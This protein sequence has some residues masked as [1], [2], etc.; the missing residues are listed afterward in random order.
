MSD[1]VDK[2]GYRIYQKCDFCGRKGA[3]YAVTPDGKAYPIVDRV[4]PDKRLCYACHSRRM[5]Q[6]CAPQEG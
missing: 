4:K 1:R 3:I 6:P 5:A 2:N